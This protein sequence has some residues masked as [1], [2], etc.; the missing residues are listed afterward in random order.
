MLAA[1]SWDQTLLSLVLAA[2]LAW[3]AYRGAARALGRQAVVRELRL[4]RDALDQVLAVLDGPALE[5]LRGETE[6]YPQREMVELERRALQAQILFWRDLDMQQALR[7]L[8]YP[9]KHAAA[10]MKLRQVLEGL[11]HD[12]HG[13]SARA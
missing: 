11:D 10:A 13:V 9:D 5:Y 7:D 4:R 12:L 6:D 2:L 1:I 3:L 8:T